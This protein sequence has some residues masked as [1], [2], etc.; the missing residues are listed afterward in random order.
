MQAE[1]SIWIQITMATV[2]VN[3]ETAARMLAKESLFTSGFKENTGYVFI[4][5]ITSWQLCKSKYY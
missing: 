4:T 3:Q 1:V 2:A 5:Q